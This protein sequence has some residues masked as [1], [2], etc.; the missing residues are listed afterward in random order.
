MLFINICKPLLHYIVHIP[1]NNSIYTQKGITTT[2]AQ[3]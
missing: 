1:T 2:Y 3:T